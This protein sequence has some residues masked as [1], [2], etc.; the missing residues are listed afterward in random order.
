MINGRWTFRCYVDHRGMNVVLDWLSKL[1]PKARQNL[2]R[3]LEQLAT[4]PKTAWERPHASPLGNHIYVIRFN[5]ENRTQWRVYGEHE[6]ERGCFVLTNY[7]TERGGKYDPPPATCVA[8]AMQHM[9]DVRREWDG[10]SCLC[11]STAS[12]GLGGPR[13]SPSNLSPPR[14]VNN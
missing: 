3:T 11:L 9:A 6:D 7:G 4:K 2:K 13:P 14:L 1:S 8:T 12:G 10:R 5:D